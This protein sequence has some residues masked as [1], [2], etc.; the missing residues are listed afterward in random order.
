MILISRFMESS[1]LHEMLLLVTQE[2][3]TYTSIVLPTQTLLSCESYN[4]KCL[5]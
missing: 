3:I 4:V 1:A 5:F 2:L